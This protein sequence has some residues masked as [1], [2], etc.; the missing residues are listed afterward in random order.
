M[1]DKHMRKTIRARGCWLMLAMTA[2]VAITQAGGCGGDAQD[3]PE[4]PIAIE[5][6]AE[7]ELGCGE[8]TK[9]GESEATCKF[10]SYADDLGLAKSYACNEAKDAVICTFDGECA[11]AEDYPPN[12]AP[13][14]ESF[15]GREPA[16]ARPAAKP[17][18]V[19]LSATYPIPAGSK[20]CSPGIGRNL[21]REGFCYEQVENDLILNL[22][23]VVGCIGQ[24]TTAKRTVECCVADP[25]ATSSSSTSSSSGEGGASSSSGGGASSSSGEGGAGGSSASSTSGSGAGLS[26]SDF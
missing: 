16:C 18:T 21:E 10:Y 4:S 11:W 9:R 5:E 23:L 25:D 24:T 6:A 12:Y 14:C 22:S 20:L 26:A 17:Q 7:A 2:A 3:E 1:E 15:L 8:G 13:Q 19:A